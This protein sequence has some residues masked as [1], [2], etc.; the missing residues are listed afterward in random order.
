MVNFLFGLEALFTTV[1]LVQSSVD[2][3]LHQTQAATG[4]YNDKSSF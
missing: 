1:S 2:L 3:T 4:P